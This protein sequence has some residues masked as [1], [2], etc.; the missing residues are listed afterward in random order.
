M[1]CIYLRKSRADM[2]AERQGIDTLARHEKILTSYAAE[3]GYSIGK[4]Y[5]EVVSGDTI[6]ARPQVQQMLQ[7]AEAGMWEGVLVMEVERLSRGA[8]IDQGIIA[9]VFK[10]SNTKIITPYK[11]YNPND[12]Y[13]EEFFEYGLFQSRREYKAITKRQQRGVL[14]S[15][16]EGKWVYNKVPYGYER[17]KLEH[18]KG[19]SLRIVPEQGKVVRMIYTLYRDGMGYSSISDYLNNMNIPAPGDH[20]TYNTVCSMLQNPVYNGKIKRGARAVV[21]T[22]EGGTLKSSR[23]RNK[24][25]NIYEGLHEPIIDDILWRTVQDKFATHPSKPVA[26]AL[27]IRNPLAGLVYCQMCGHK[28]IRRPQDRCRTMIICPVKSCHNISCYESV[29]E[30][31]VIDYLCKY[32]EELKTNTGMSID[33]TTIE[34]LKASLQKSNK[35]IEQLNNQLDNAYDLVEQGVYSADIFMKRQKSINGKLAAEKL[36]NEGITAQIHKEEKVIRQR[37]TL[38]PRIENTLNVYWDLDPTEKN[39]MLCDIIDHIDYVKTE[40]SKKNGPYNNFQIVVHPRIP[41]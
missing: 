36:K 25:Y 23:P 41:V 14:Q 16:Q 33:T 29:L 18:E 13:D 4:I 1:Y 12:E 30:Q 21:K 19:Y 6:A 20:W 32:L 38:I 31:T 10:F 39:R 2:D 24:H 26:K 40:R 3:H 35:E 8:T 15:C 34:I 28:M 5:R 11:V 27:E 22:T 9:Q 7:D 17:Y 37:D